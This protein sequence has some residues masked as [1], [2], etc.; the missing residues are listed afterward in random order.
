MNDT[1]TTEDLEQPATSRERK[2]RLHDRVP[3]RRISSRPADIRSA[4]T[5]AG[6]MTA[7]DQIVRS[8]KKVL[9]MGAVHIW[10]V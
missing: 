3:G 2:A 4:P 1:V 6:H 5:E 10:L 7:A 9:A 8:V